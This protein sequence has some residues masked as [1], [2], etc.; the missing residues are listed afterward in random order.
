MRL[1]STQLKAV[2]VIVAGMLLLRSAPAAAV[3]P[4]AESGCI[5]GCCICVDPGTDGTCVA[6]ENGFQNDYAIQC[7]D[8][9]GVITGWAACSDNDLRCEGQT[10][11]TTLVDCGVP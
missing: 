11:Y 6:A 10:Q 9:C 7:F 2:G 4:Q 8:Q 5:E 3:A 1:K